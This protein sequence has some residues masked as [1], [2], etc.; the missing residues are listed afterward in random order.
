MAARWPFRKWHL[1]KPIGFFPYTQSMCYLSLDLIFKAKLKNLIWP[2]GG[3]F[4]SDISA[5]QKALV[6]WT[7]RLIDMK[8]IAKKPET[9]FMC[10][11]KELLVYLSCNSFEVHMKFTWSSNHSKFIWIPCVL[12]ANCLWAS[13]QLHNIS[14][15]WVYHINFVIPSIWSSYELYTNCM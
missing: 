10:S 14:I 7:W 12:Q 5:N 13:C 3:Q 11:T 2:P 1:W 9:I 15:T 6:R 4:E 8:Y